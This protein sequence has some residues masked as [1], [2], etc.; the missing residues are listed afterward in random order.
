MMTAATGGSDASL[1][2]KRLALTCKISVVVV[3]DLESTCLIGGHRVLHS[4]RQCCT[5]RS[6]LAFTIKI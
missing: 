5:F 1:G 2:L 6:I 4:V 3:V